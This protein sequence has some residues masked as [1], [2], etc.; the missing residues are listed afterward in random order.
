MN[1]KF[2]NG[3]KPEVIDG[4]KQTLADNKAKAEELR[5]LKAGLAA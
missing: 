3:A 4:V 5:K 2:L 1:D